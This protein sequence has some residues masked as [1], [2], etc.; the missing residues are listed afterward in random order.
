MEIIYLPKEDNK[1]A[2]LNIYVIEREAWSALLRWNQDVSWIKI[3]AM[4]WYSY[5]LMLKSKMTR[6][7]PDGG[8]KVCSAEEAGL[9]SSG[10]SSGAIPM[11]M[12]TM[13]TRII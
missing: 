2:Y 3:Q 4:L 7:G 13:S 5:D 11:E 8:K 1:E 6:N 10:N 12:M 9:D